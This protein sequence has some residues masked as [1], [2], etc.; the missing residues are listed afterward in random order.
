[1][2][3]QARAPRS[4]RSG[5]P[6]RGPVISLG[7]TGSARPAARCTAVVHP[8]P[9]RR[10]RRAAP[11]RSGTRPRRRRRTDHERDLA[12]PERLRRRR[13]VRA[14]ERRMPGG[15]GETARQRVVRARVRATRATGIR[16]GARF[17]NAMPSPA[18]SST[19]K[20]KTQK[21]A[22]GSRIELA[23]AHQRELDE[24]V[25]A[26]AAAAQSSRSCRPVSETKT[27]S[28]V[29]EW[30]RSS[31]SCDALPPE[32][33]RAA[34]AW[35]RCSSDTWSRQTPSCRPGSPPPTTPGERP[36]V[37][38]RRRSATA[39]S[40]TC[41]APSDAI[42][43]RG[44]PSGDH[45]PV[46]HDGHAI[47]EPLG[48]VHVVGGEQDGAAAGAGSARSAPRAAGGTAGRARWWARRGTAARGRR[49]ARRPAPA[50][51]AGRR[52]AG[53]PGRPPSR[54]SWTRSITSSGLGTARDRSCGTAGPSR[55]P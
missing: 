53:R 49:P 23:V 34:R 2:P 20:M 10:A 42:S 29:A 43:S 40:S 1:M 21:T 30:V 6:A 16:S 54:R 3:E 27:S 28:S 5:R 14:S 33:V 4:R 12:G 19:G 9:R 52:R 46:V 48:L 36:G 11:D 51:A 45:A 47:A 22:S 41:S 39:N 50:A 38:P 8:Q 24:R 31:E 35:P 44:V 7:R 55:P 18:V 15:R 32:L 13:V 26:P 25:V 37:E 17:R